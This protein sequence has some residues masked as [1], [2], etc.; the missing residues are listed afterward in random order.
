MVPPMTVR[1][2]LSVIGD[3]ISPSLRGMISF[4]VEHGVSRLD[5]RTVGGRSLL[6]MKLTE[7][8]EIGARLEHAGIR[9]P[10]FVSPLLK[11]AASGKQSTEDKVDFA[12]D[13]RT[14][15][16]EDPLEHACDVA[17]V[18]RASKLRFFSYL[19]HRDFKARDLLATIERL[20]DLS[21]LH[22]TSMR[23][24]NEPVC[25]LG[26]IPELAEFFRQLP[27]LLAIVHDA[28]LLP[29]QPLPDIANSYAMGQPPRDA[30][31]AVLAPNVDT[32]H[33]KD[34]RDGRT[35]PF[36]D[37]DIPWAKELERLLKD[38][39]A[40]DVVASIETHCPQNARDATAR[41][42]AGLRRIADEVGIELV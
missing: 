38:V 22:V 37:G 40:T 33:L 7:V 34:W 20:M 36:G 2:A 6:G 9:V 19:R 41:S 42:V 17:D 18:L 39:R 26:S 21:G 23:L 29:I 28:R 27:D 8:A 32:I 15:P 5:M 12:F 30:D 31:I 3:E 16:V 24:E 25:N 1:L 4:C 10:T 13:P 11:W 14:C 35:V